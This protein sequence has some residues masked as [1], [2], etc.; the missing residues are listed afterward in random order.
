VSDLA[1]R[2]MTTEEFDAWVPGAIE[3]Y[4]ADHVRAGSKQPD[5]ALESAKQEFDTLLPHGV[6]TPSH[7]LLTATVDDTSVGILWLH[8]PDGQTPPRVFIY[9]IEV[10]ESAR[11][12]GYGRAIMLAAE[13][14]ARSYGADTIRLHVF[15]DNT[16]ARSLY[17]SLGYE[18]TNISMAKTL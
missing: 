9:D 5:T 4:A 18:A 14:Y 17:D 16:V 12:R 8:I 15:G 13:D 1:L 7:H 2:P 6:E 10:D 11:G 3:A